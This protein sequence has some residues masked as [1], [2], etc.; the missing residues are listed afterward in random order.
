M[1]S[2]LVAS[3]YD[4]ATEGSS[5][6]AWVGSRGETERRPWPLWAVIVVTIL[7]LASILWIPVVAICRFDIYIH[8]IFINMYNIR[9][10]RLH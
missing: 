9:I 1:I 7:V 2:I 6:P 5:Y 3:V 4:I 8:D 10:I